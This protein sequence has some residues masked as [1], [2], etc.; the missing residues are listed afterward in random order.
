LI[1]IYLAAFFAD[2]I[3]PNITLLGSVFPTLIVTAVAGFLLIVQRD[4]GT[5]SLFVCLYILMLTVTMQKRRFLWL[6]PM[7]A[8]IAGGIG[9][10]VFDVVR[11]RIDIWLNP[12]PASGSA[13]QLVQAQIALAGGR[14]GREQ[15]QAWAALC[16][17]RW[18]FRTLSS[19]QLQ[20]RLA[21]L[22]VRL[23]SS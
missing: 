12:G 21:C 6:I 23:Y 10:F 9:Y 15:G 2:Q 22:A 13:Y 1:I 7:A 3:K 20:K 8:I 18:R 14:F 11:A 5:A 19:R 16:S 4:L 17:F